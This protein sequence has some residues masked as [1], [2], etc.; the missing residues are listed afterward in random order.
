MFGFL[1]RAKPLARLD[2]G[3]PR[4]DALAAVRTALEEGAK[5]LTR[6]LS[7]AGI[8]CAP[9]LAGK[10]DPSAT[11]VST[12]MERALNYE[13]GGRS[14]ALRLGKTPEFQTYDLETHYRY[15]E[16]H[17]LIE[18]LERL[19]SGNVELRR[20]LIRQHAAHAL[21]PRAGS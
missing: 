1:N 10:G 4:D 3:T 9:H 14:Y 11:P 15:R 19:A 8:A 17:L 16:I 7:E 21:I 12:L 20:Q 18:D 5:Y 6:A 13:D 2:S